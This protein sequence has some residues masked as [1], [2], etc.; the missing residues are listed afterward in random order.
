MNGPRG[1]R[2]RP[3]GAG[4]REGPGR[5]AGCP[6]P[7]REAAGSRPFV[8]L[9]GARAGSAGGTI[10]KAGDKVLGVEIPLGSFVRRARF[11]P[12]KKRCLLG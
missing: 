4:N 8:R 5:A 6:A 2:G 1:L 12:L 3:L 10:C 11:P 7:P 9:R